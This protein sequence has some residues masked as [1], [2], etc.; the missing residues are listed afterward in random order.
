MAQRVKDAGLALGVNTT[1]ETDDADHTL[2]LDGLETLGKG[3]STANLDN[4]VST[5]AVGSELAGRLAPVGV[6]L[7]V[8]NVV[9]TELLQLLGL[10]FRRGSGNDGRTG[11]FSEL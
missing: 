8:D 2:E 1:K 6:G 10:R 4:V 3:A 9:G 7:V 11:G 5:R